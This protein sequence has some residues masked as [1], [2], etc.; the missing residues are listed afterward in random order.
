M[1]SVFGKPARLHPLLDP[2]LLCM[3]GK[4]GDNVTQGKA[5][6][7]AVGRLLGGCAGGWEGAV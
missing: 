7:G 5:V 4:T 1:Y 6:P 3:M 2:T